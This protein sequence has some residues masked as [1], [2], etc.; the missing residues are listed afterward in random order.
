MSKG[1]NLLRNG[2]L[3]TEQGKWAKAI[4]SLEDALKIFL[5]ADEAEMVALTRSFLGVALRAQKRYD[6]ALSQFQEL[7]KG[8]SE[9][10]DQFGVA[11]AYF[12]IGL[13][14]SLQKN[15]DS[16]LEMMQKCLKIVK[17]DLKDKDVEA[18]TLA[19]LGGIYLLK[20]DF[21]TAYSVYKEGAEIADSLDFIEGSAECAKGMAE[22]HGSWGEFEHAEKYYQKSLGL[23]RIMREKREEANIL[24]RLGVIYS[25]VGN[26][27]D[28]IFYFKQS[29]KLKKALGDLVGVN[30]CEKN[31]KAIPSKLNEK[32]LKSPPLE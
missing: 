2:I 9:M 31:L 14:F 25:K 4:R 26:N 3:L 6:D 10:K 1:Q 32:Q 15:Y 12:D 24:L 7:L 19:N 29:R 21:H 22:V 5:T 11:Q 30:L 28:A 20:G 8:L 17:D 13:T 23:F 18:R 16:A 27:Q